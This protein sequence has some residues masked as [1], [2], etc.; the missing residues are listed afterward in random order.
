MYGIKKMRGLCGMTQQDLADKLNCTKS[1]ISLLEK[2]SAKT[3]SISEAEKIATIFNCSI[4]DIYDIDNLKY[5]PQNIEETKELI[6]IILKDCD[7]STDDRIVM[8][9]ELI[10]ECM[11]WE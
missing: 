2:E 1:Y 3:I 7:D 8:L 9:K 10:S 5:R 4:I 6:R 11:G